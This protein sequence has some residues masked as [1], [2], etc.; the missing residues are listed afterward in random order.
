[1]N[2]KIKAPRGQ[3]TADGAAGIDALDTSFLY[4]ELRRNYVT[5]RK[6]IDVDFREMVSWIKGGDQLTHHI[7]PYPAKLLPQIANFFCRA[8]I[9]KEASGIL[10][11]PF[12]GSGTVALEA[13]MAG[14]QPYV[15]DANPFALMLSRVKTTPYCVKE[16]EECLETL[17]SRSAKFRSAPKV[18]IVNSDLWYSEENKFALERIIRSIHELEDKSTRE[19]F[20]ICFS[21]LARKISYADPRV[22][23]PVRQ[24]IKDSFSPAAKASVQARFDWLKNVSAF[25]EFS[26]ICNSNINRVALTNN[27]YPSRNCIKELGDDARNLRSGRRR[28]GAPLPDS[29]VSLIITSPPYG[30]AQ[31]YVRASSLALNWLGLAAPKDLSALERRSIGREHLSERE[32]LSLEGI[33]KKY[34]H[35]LDRIS[36]VNL[37]RA[38]LTA[39]YMREMSCVVAELSR[40]TASGGRNVLIVG[41]NQVCGEVISNDQF[42]QDCFES[43]GMTTEL[44]VR[45]DIRARGLMTTRNRATPAISHE[46]VLVF[47][48]GA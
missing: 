38:K 6:T 36:R 44:S 32:S 10:L 5:H 26:K 3:A 19:F 14:I 7:H 28:L 18:E 8:S 37:L 47:R 48:K 40:V 31:K 24:K 30:S 20:L 33:S 11:D 35:Q 43:H 42:L 13:S 27:A 1:M 22:N 29:S 23:V 21:V 4:E 2:L 9:L 16:L 41:N 45:D 39:T 15:A 46:T 25:D 34:R 12:C 17:R